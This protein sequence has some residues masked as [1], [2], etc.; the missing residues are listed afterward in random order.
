MS[1][2]ASFSIIDA[3]AHLD[4]RHF[5][6]DRDDVIRRARE[7]GVGTIVN[8]GIDLKSSRRAISLAE[9]YPEVVAAVGIHPNDT[10][11]V[12]RED[13]DNLAALAR[14]PQVVAI[15]EIGL[16]FYR[17]HSPP[18]RQ[19]ASL[20]WQLALAAERDLPVIIHCRQ[21]EQELVPL[22]ERWAADRQCPAGRVLGIIHCFSGP[23]ATADKY[24]AMGFMISLGAYIGYP[25]SR[26]MVEVI[27]YLPAD[28][29]LVE[30]D[31]PFL[32]PKN[33]RGKRNEPSYL[34]Q[35]VGV[36]AEIRRESPAAIAQ[37]TTANARRLFRLPPEG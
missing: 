20:E 15:G 16:D 14:S 3:H 17:D 24:L 25:S 19:Q 31:C 33:R 5:D 11:T 32:P 13:I 10:A 36:L 34:P 28:S 35:T 9:T 7:A 29:L 18:E 12:S 8:V 1:I 27:R 6:S 21:A 4:M 2:K 23:V 22:L 26:D 30:T 37:T